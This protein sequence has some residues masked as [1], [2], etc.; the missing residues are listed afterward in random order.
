LA[1]KVVFDIAGL[2]VDDHVEELSSTVG[3]MLLKPT[4]IYAKAM[5]KIQANYPV[6]SVV[7]GVAHITGG[8]LHE[9][10]ARIMP[11]G[12]QAVIA[13][14][15]WPVPPVFTWMQR[16]GEIDQEEM[17]RVFNLGLGLVLV[18]SPYYAQSIRSQ[19]EDCGLESWQL[20]QVVAGP[21]GVVWA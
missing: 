15:S 4:R 9:N 16:L 17:D 10:L 1:R 5:R 19:L 14:N 6:K 8:G 12:T 7:H 11:P 13:R 18:V 3:E 20:G 21:T 2:S